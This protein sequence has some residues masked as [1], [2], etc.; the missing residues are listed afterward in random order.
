MDNANVKPG[1]LKT[2]PAQPAKQTGNYNPTGNQGGRQ[3]A[4]EGNPGQKGDTQRKAGIPSYGDN[5]QD[6]PDVEA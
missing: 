3:G 2:D 5:P 6:L 1:Q 4:P